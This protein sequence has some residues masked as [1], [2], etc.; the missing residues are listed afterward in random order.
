MRFVRLRRGF[1]LIELLIVVAI[2]GILAAI[3]VPNFLNAQV[4]AKIARTKADVRMLDDQA[5]IRHMDTGM[6]LIDGDDCGME[7]INDERC[8]H[9]NGVHFFGKTPSQVGLS[10]I[11]QD[12]H[13]NGQ[14]W[15]LLTTPVAYIGG[16]PVDPFGK[17][18]FYGYV[19]RDCSNSPRGTWYMIFAAG[20]D[21]VYYG[22][23]GSTQRVIPYN[24]SN[25]LA[26][27]G[28]IWRSRKL[29]D[30]GSHMPYELEVLQDYW[31]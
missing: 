3:A 13:F 15:A 5:V 20:P 6:W 25:G 10:N 2:I 31:D 30:V 12:N 1:T 23:W 26:S 28:D 7:G 29:R 17:G 18:C 19:D 21:G 9:A 27:N 11:L 24:A 8:C 4:R 14:N 16:I 22:D